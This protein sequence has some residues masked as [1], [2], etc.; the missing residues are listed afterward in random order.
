MERWCSWAMVSKG[1]VVDC[2][3]GGSH[4]TTTCFQCEGRTTS[5]CSHL[6]AALG[7]ACPSLLPSLPHSPPPPLQFP[8]LF[9]STCSISHVLLQPPLP[10]PPPVFTP[11][12]CHQSQAGIT[13]WGFPPPAHPPGLCKPLFE[14][15]KPSWGW[16]FS[17]T[18]CYPCFPSHAHASSPWLHKML[19]RRQGDLRDSEPI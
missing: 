15:Q 1:R 9:S 7:C 14:S 13:P 8:A 17:K 11:V 5:A 12:P 4:G 18:P 3:Q 6:P 19:D 16:D 2:A 10:Q